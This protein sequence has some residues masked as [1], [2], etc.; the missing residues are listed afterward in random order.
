KPINHLLSV[1]LG[2]HNPP[3]NRMQAFADL[4]NMFGA[5]PHLVHEMDAIAYTHPVLGMC[6]VAAQP[7][8]MYW[9][10]PTQGAAVMPQVQQMG[11][12][13][14]QAMPSGHPLA[15]QQ[16]QQMLQ[17]QHQHMSQQHRRM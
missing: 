10:D 7:Q 6:F 9:A 1:I 11:Y 8:Y 4:R 15:Q 14:M 16:Q 5:Y 2:D 13:Q 17:Q 3:V 12:Y